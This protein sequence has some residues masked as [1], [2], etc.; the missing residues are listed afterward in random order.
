MK[1][2]TT[3]THEAPELMREFGAEVWEE[4]RVYGGRTAKRKGQRRTTQRRAV[5]QRA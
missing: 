4:K 5:V 1:P 3:T 2:R